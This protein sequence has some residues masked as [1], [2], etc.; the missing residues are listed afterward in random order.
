ME[1]IIELL[2]QI[3]KLKDLKRTGWVN[4]K[5]PNPESVA[6]HTF[7]TSIMALLLAGKLGLDKD[8]CVK[9]ALVH[10]ISESL[11]GDITPHDKIDAKEKH[12]RERTAMETLFKDIEEREI[13]NLWNEYEAKETPES[14]FIYQLDK[15]EMVLQ[16]YE[17]E[18]KHDMQLPE[19]WS[20]VEDKI[21]DPKLLEILDILKVKK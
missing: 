8:R 21:K 15:L 4:N 14:R 5:V 19:F 9:L 1:K 12:D 13:F 7:R 6:D 10:D 11:V 20:Y 18:K 16:A 17:Y 2:T 3:G